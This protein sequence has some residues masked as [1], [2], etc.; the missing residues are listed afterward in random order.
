MKLF[1]S[2]ITIILMSILLLGC[3]NV[4]TESQSSNKLS[5]YTSVYPIQYIVERI[6]GDTV[7]TTSIFPPGVDAHTYEPTAKTMTTLARSD[8]F[9]YFGTGMEGF[10]ESIAEALESV[11]ISLLELGEYEELFE[12]VEHHHVESN[13]VE[14]EEHEEHHHDGHNHGDH[15]P[16]IW[17][18]PLRMAEMGHIITEYL[19]ELNPDQKRL[20]EENF[21][22]LE[23]DLHQLD[24]A[25]SE[26]LSKKKNKE[27]LV[28]HAA[29]GYWEERYGIEQISINGLS[30]SSEP[31]QRD[32]VEIIEQA[33]ASQL[34]YVIVEQ[35]TSSKVTEIIQEHIGA[36]ALSIHN[37]AVLT[38]KDVK[39]KSDYLSIMRHNLSVLDL[40]TQ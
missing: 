30:S 7:T 21:H 31:S 26:E 17:I 32:L 6:G 16:H 14:P 1:T 24:E 33:E 29:Y 25:F 4:N 15:D 36:E 2:L 9:I 22:L 10:T 40:A 37:L 23:L 20:Y 5:I 8:A 35:N 27:I 39:E 18:D 19:I 3:T 12:E 28:S 13:Q 38:E 34:Q 11:D